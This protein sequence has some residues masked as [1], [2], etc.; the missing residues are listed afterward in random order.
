MNNRSF[1]SILVKVSLYLSLL[2]LVSTDL[3]AQPSGYKY[4]KRV[5]LESDE[6]YGSTAHTNYPL[7]ISVTDSDMRSVANGGGVESSSGFDIL[8]T[9]LTGTPLDQQLQ[10]YEPTTGKVIIWTQIASLPTGTDIEGYIY[11]GNSSVYSDQSTSDIWSTDFIGVW[12]LD[13]L[14]DATGN[15]NDLINTNT[16]TNT[17]GIVG[18]AREFDGDGDNLQDAGGDTYL[19]GLSEFTV[20]LWAK[21]DA[22]GS[23]RGMLHGRDPN[24][25][26]NRLQIRF[27]AAGASGGGTNVIRLNSRINDNGTKTNQILESSNNIQDTGWHYYTL[28]WSSGNTFTLYVDGIADSPSFTNNR[29]GVSFGNTKL[30][31]GRGAKDG[32]TSSWDGLI[33]EVWIENVERSADWIRTVHN[34]MNNPGDF[35]FIQNINETPVVSNIETIDL[36]YA[37]LSGPVSITQS[38]TVTDYNDVYLDSVAAQIFTNYQSAEDTLAFVSQ[39]GITSY[40]TEAN[41][42]LHLTGH[43]HQSD[44]ETALRAITYENTS[45][46]PNTSTRTIRFAV[47]DAAGLSNVVTRDVVFDQPNSTPTLASIEGTT[48]NY[49]D[50]YGDTTLTASITV[51]DVDDAYLD[52]AEISITSNFVSGE[53]VLGFSNTASLTGSWNGVS[54]SLLIVGTDSQA[55]YQTALRA[56]TYRNVNPDPTTSTRTIQF[57]VTD[58]VDW[59]TSV[60]R[61][62]TVTPLNNAP[63]LEGIESSAIV[64]NAG[65]GAVVI[66][67]SIEV[68]DGDDT[69]LDSARVKITANY[70][71]TE[72][73]LDFTNQL[74][75]TGTWFSGAG[76]LLLQGSASLASY[77]S[78]LQAVTYENMATQPKSPTRTV[79]INVHDGDASSN[80]LTRS[81][82]SGA[83][84]T[85][86][87]LELWLRADAEVY[88]DAGVNLCTDGQGVDR[89]DDQSGHDYDFIDNTTKPIWRASVPS[90]NNAPAIE[91]AGTGDHFRDGDGEDY[92]NG[93]T[94]FT[95]FSVIQSDQTSTDRGWFSARNPGNGDRDLT[96]RYDAIGDNSAENNV[97]KSGILLNN[98]A[99]Q[100]ESPADIQSIDPQIVAL[101]WKSGFVYEM[102][103]DG[104]LMNPSTQQNIPVGTITTALRVNIGQGPAV[105]GESWDG[106]IAEVILYSKSISENERLKIED[107]LSEKY[108]ISTGLID[109]ADGADSLSVDDIGGSFTS[110]TGPRITEDVIGEFSDNGTVVLSLPN[111]YEW[112]TGGAAPSLTVEAAYGASTDL[113]ASF[114]SRTSSSVTY[115][116]DSPSA[117]PNKPGSITFNGLRIRPTTS[118]IPTAGMITNTGATGPAS[119][120]DLGTLGLVAGIADSLVFIVA[121]SS[122]NA[123][124]AISPALEVQLVDQHGNA[125][126]SSGVSITINLTT[127]TGTLSGNT[128]QPTD[129]DG[130]A[131]FNDLSINFT[132]T[133]RLTA[134]ATGL[135]STE[136]T[137]FSIAPSGEYTTFKIERSSGGNI[138]DQTAGSA[139]TIKISAVDATETVDTDFTGT[140]DLTT[141]S[142]FV[143][144]GGTSSSFVAGVLSSLTVNLGTAGDHTLTATTTG[145][146]INGSSNTFTI[147]PGSAS[148]ATTQI[149][150]SP[151]AIANNGISTSTIT[152]T[153]T[154]A[155]NNILTSGGE[156]VNIVTDA[157]TLL[158]SPTD[159]SDGTYTQSLQ[160]STTAETAT[161]TGLLNLVDITDDAALQFNDYSTIWQSSP[162]AADSTSEWGLASNWTDGVPDNADDVLIPATPNNGTRQPIISVDNRQMNDLTIES[163][164]DVTLSGSISFEVLGD[165]LGNGEVNGSAQDSIIVRG[166]F[167]IGSLAIGYVALEGTTVQDIT[168]I[169]SFQTLEINNS[170]GVEATSS[171]TV[172]T[173]LKLTSGTLVLP[174]GAILIANT[175]TVAS[176]DIQLGREISGNTGWRVLGAPL[177]STYGDFLD[178]LFTQ[179]YTGSDSATGSPSVLWYDE[180]YGGTDNQRWRKPSNI[181]D[182]TVPGRGLFVYVFGNI[183]G[184]AAY[185]KDLPAILDIA[186]DEDLGT[187]DVF[188]FGVTYTALAD[189]GW[190]LI[191]NP[192]AATIDWDAAGW[193]KTNMDNTIYVWDASLNS[194]NG[195]YLTWN[196]TTGSLGDGLIKPFQGFWVKANAS[197]PELKLN[198]SN[199]TSGGVFYKVSD[200]PATLVFHAELDTLESLTHLVFKQSASLGKDAFD[201]YQLEA[202]SQT[203][204]DFFSAGYDNPELTINTLPSRFGIPLEVALDIRA[205]LDGSPI[206]GAATLRWPQMLNLPE[207]WILTLFD[208][209]TNTS[210]NIQNED[211]YSFETHTMGL[212]RPVPPSPIGPGTMPP[213]LTK[214]AAK[215]DMRF[216]LRIDPGNAFPDLP[217]KYGLDGNYPNPFNPSTHIR[218]D[219][220]L[221]SA[222]TLKIYDVLGREV[223]AP[224]ED[225]T[226]PAGKHEII[227]AANELPSGI[228][229]A[230]V[231]MRGK[232]FTQKMLLLR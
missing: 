58:G 110:L 212:A 147:D 9:S 5:L 163:G 225:T 143:S 86:S 120:V 91:F 13:N 208:R 65:D 231:Q 201:A 198:V 179:G 71:S 80:T 169:Q 2:L 8:L 222:I 100:L 126:D 215:S 12:H 83:P 160:S 137:D 16:A 223:A 3:V 67:N 10:A 61:D 98:V 175:Q 101:Q 229:I 77:E 146:S 204:L 82:S 56:V 60:S 205:W 128:S 34:N 228:Y 27:D 54:G 25:N 180:T 183:P 176:G 153:V 104:V 75:I 213:R 44:Y 145:A 51:S 138:L 209:E 41:T 170:A 23:D 40:W 53:D 96:L 72:D 90:L 161:I 221:E 42:I 122:G 105:S 130:M 68:S 55:D 103:V 188:D 148:V 38:V 15:N 88:S 66:T 193:T 173:E 150:A 43:A 187:A 46:T 155:Y 211:S 135:S 218:L 171:L 196:G 189:T 24:N 185:S 214:T 92:V 99:N 84:G 199:K 131:S 85:I 142:S 81:I 7:M 76:E 33:D 220:P 52:S 6:V 74:G 94:E 166:D 224:L 200:I 45:A 18:S 174:T 78:A 186:G 162:G 124:E 108:A 69:D 132:G 35:F 119:S 102:W 157:G 121:P 109:P 59:S 87:D 19:D 152:V 227:W 48:F 107:Y 29:T 192:F 17:S 116:I 197:A 14:M 207:G 195:G 210:I 134:S 20:S 63:E 1:I 133:K 11:F 144:G 112:D 190:N 149:T 191:A 106:H 206:A 97:I 22:T 194:G 159:N 230:L 136:S 203:R 39:N 172:S 113:T 165:L 139:F 73:E 89:W 28:T 151:T 232:F 168:Q 32:T 64:Y 125:R 184:E 123:T 115:T 79:D 219:L 93:M 127:G 164:A 167:N 111:G 26:D 31:I 57:S 70:F 37:T 62:L 154:D 216:L 178:S 4:R 49:P 118:T 181:T 21:A 202:P 141:S 156:T 226:Y 129:V 182:A 117:A 50:S 114:T 158:S 217:R 36:N 140:I 30:I 95:L 47:Y 177:T